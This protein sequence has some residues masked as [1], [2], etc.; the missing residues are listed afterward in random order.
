[1]SWATLEGQ[2]VNLGDKRLNERF[3][4]LL[5]RLSQ[6]T[7]ASLPAACRGHA[8]LAAAYRFF[9]NPKVTT[10]ALL[11]PHAQATLQRAQGQPVILIPQDSTEHDFT[12]HPAT[13]GLGHL[14]WD[15]RRG[16]FAH[17]QLAFTPAGV[18]LG[19]LHAEFWIHPPEHKGKR[20]RCKQRLLTDKES[21]RWL[22]GL[23][24]AAA[25]AEQLPSTQVVSLADR[26]SDIYECLLQQAGLGAGRRL[27][28]VIRCQYDRAT[29]RRDRSAGRRVY[30]K[31]H[32]VVRQTPVLQERTLSL[33]RTPKRAARL[34]RVQVQ[35]ARVTL[36]PPARPAGSEP[37]PEVT[38]N[39]VRVAEVDAPAG[40][41]PVEWWL[42]TSLPIDGLEQVA[43]VVRYYEC[44]WYIEPF[45]KTW[46]DGCR[47]EELQLESRERLEVAAA[48]YLIVAWRVEYLT[49]QARQQG[50]EPCAAYVEESEWKSVV[51]TVRGVEATVQGPPDVRTFVRLLARLGG[52]QGRK[53]D[54][55]PGTKVVW[56]GLRQ[57]HTLARAWDAFGP[58][59]GPLFM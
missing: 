14:N 22:Q 49:R 11:R 3:V 43:T 17:L 48:L 53:G 4:L 25:W 27:D 15:E 34:A 26:E 16:F 30:H 47:I 8:E 44:R 23:R 32:D 57:M 56:R 54:G 40:V 5:D 46:K 2:T 12:H 19:C 21:F 50:S 7:Q 6:D 9:D 36:R 42:W 45:I 28:W 59:T 31:A 24:R 41:E 39:L 52:W 55:E 29:N 58:S 10:D 20:H 13:T 51:A 38:V 18:P 35:A 37:L 33:Q 1:M